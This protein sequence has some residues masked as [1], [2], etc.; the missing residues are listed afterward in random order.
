M[1]LLIRRSL[2]PVFTSPTRTRVVIKSKYFSAALLFRIADQSHDAG[3]RDFDHVHQN[4][5]L[6]HDDFERRKEIIMSHIILFMQPLEIF[7]RPMLN[8]NYE[9]KP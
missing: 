1:Q 8:S 2:I 5:F 7:F 6:L 4:V 9:K 3:N